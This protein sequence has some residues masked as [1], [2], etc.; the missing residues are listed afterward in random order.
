ME[1]CYLGPIL[2]CPF[3]AGKIYIWKV[4]GKKQ[5]DWASLYLDD[6]PDY[7][8]GLLY[9][10]FAAAMDLFTTAGGRSSGAGIG[11]DR[12]ADTVYTR[13]WKAVFGLCLFFNQA[14][15]MGIP[16]YTGRAGSCGAR[17]GCVL[18]QRIPACQWRK[19]P[20]F[21]FYILEK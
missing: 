12:T 20:V 15:G 9:H 2:F 3:D 21:I 11:K 8:D 7:L 18:V 16:P 6:N 1:F 13:I 10:R 4:Y 19:Q 14:A 17:A 5:A